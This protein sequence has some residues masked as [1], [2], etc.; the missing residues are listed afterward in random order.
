MVL[1]LALPLCLGGCARLVAGAAAD[2]LS[3]AVLNQNDP[4]LIRSGVPAYLLLVD[5]LISQ[6]PE[7]ADLLAAGAQLFSLY[8]SRFAEDA[9][10]AADLTSKARDYGDRAACIAVEE[11][12]GAAGLPY[13]AFVSQLSEFDRKNIDYLYVFSISWLSNLDATSEDWSA[14]AELPW[15]EAAMERVLAVDETH[16]AGALHGYL[17]ILK[18]LRPPAL[19]GEPAAAQAHFERAIELSQG[20]DLSIK[21][22]YARRYAR[23][24][25]EQDLHDR[26]LREV[27][28][29]PASVAGYTLFNTLAKEEAAELLATSADYF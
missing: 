21:V 16:D 25:F 13:D 26:L 2:T 6:S 28:D 9:A 24:M 20:R 12:C 19:G 4:R 17:G 10:H 15:V 29:S 7:N 14:V 3:A 11:F 1:A 18:S 8:G 5:G 22:E 27:L 23:M